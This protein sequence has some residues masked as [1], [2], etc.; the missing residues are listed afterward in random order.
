[1]HIS[2]TVLYVSL[3]LHMGMLTPGISRALLPPK[4]QEP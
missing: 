3:N 1:M 2:K 4:V